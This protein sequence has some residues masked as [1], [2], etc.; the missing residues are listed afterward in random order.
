VGTAL[1]SA[2]ANTP[3]VRV[4]NGTQV[5]NNAFVDE[6]SLEKARIILNQA[7]NMMGQRIA[8]P[9]SEVKILFPDSISGRVNKVLNSEYVPGIENEVNNWGPRGMWQI[10]PA[11]RLTT[12]KLDDLSTGAWYWGAPQRQFVR[13]WK[14]RFEYMTLGSDTESYLRR[15]VAFQARIAWDVEVGA[16]DYVYWYQMLPATTAPKDGG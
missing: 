4:P 15:R 6:T 3:G 14:L 9:M 10:P 5:Q 12:P 8:T 2:T 7:K 13:K 1:F 11:R 16:T